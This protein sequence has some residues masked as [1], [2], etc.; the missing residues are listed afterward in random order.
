MSAKRISIRHRLVVWTLAALVFIL[1]GIGLAAHEVA[2]HE[3][4]E[5][6]SARL[7][8][9]A[10]VLEALVA[11]Q[12]ERSTITHPIVIT[13]PPE[14]ARAEGDDPREYGHPYENK[15]AFQI[16]DDNGKLLARSASAP[17]RALSPLV[18]GFSR[19]V[20]E[21]EVWQVFMLRTGTVWVVT[22]EKDEVREEMGRE[23]G[24]AILTPLAIGGVLMLLIVNLVLSFNMRSLR[25][26]AERI[27]DRDPESL[28]RIELPDTPEELAP[29]VQELNDLLQ[30]VQA[31]FEREQRFMDAAAHEI[32]TPLAALQ[33]HMQNAARAKSAV[34]RES[35]LTEAMS[36]LKRT[37]NLAEQLLVFSRI[38]TK[39]DATS[40]APVSLNEICSEVIAAHEPLLEAKW[41]S[42]GL[43]ASRPWM[44][45]GDRYK[46]QR[47]LQNL[48]DN[49][50]QHGAQ[51]GDI[52]VSLAGHDGKVVLR[53]SNDGP[54]IP[55]EEAER[56]FTPYYRL[57]GRRGDGVGL[58]LAMVKEIAE[59]HEAEVAV[60]PKENGQGTVV[61]VLFR[62]APAGT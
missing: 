59:Q 30:R 26:L 50:S 1:G 23:L 4:D 38:A 17:E 8:S 24:T 45:R 51:H 12:I 33:L 15:I 52:E 19:R 29:I 16:W 61:S 42:I 3:S 55:P 14:L 43:D 54:A 58:G 25:S 47:L 5:I 10:R 9:S 46:L 35:S 56:I 44:V 2:R 40:F 22:A 28:A 49:A 7:A 36:A 13:L 48:I 18:A 37:T 21:Y 20:L 60:R 27:A 34:E 39:G 31:V 41:Q 11:R 53:V 6:F 32:R 57:P 62:Q